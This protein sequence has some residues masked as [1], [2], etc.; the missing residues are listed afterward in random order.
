MAEILGEDRGLI[1]PQVLL[2]DQKR[3]WCIGVSGLLNYRGIGNETLRDTDGAIARLEQDDEPEVTGLVLSPFGGDFI[4]VI[5]SAKE[6]ARKEERVNV[7]SFVVIYHSLGSGQ[8]AI[9]EGAKIFTHNEIRGMSE[10]HRQRRI[11]RNSDAFIRAIA[12]QIQ[13]RHVSRRKRAPQAA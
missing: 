4:R 11:A 9:A 1:V 8:G 7:M 13:S 3:E 6:L 2:V 12:P 5:R 10:T